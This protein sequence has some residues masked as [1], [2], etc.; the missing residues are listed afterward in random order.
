MLV[1]TCVVALR[2]T[3]TS[4]QS[5]V[6]PPRFHQSAGGEEE[7]VWSERGLMG[8]CVDV[9]SGWMFGGGGSGGGGGGSGGGGSVC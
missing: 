6:S 2:A 3:P 8:E 7:G 9:R 5:L 4:P 1:N